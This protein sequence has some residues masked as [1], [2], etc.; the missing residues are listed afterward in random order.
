MTFNDT[1]VFNVGPSQIDVAYQQ[2]GDASS[3]T[4]LLIQGIGTQLLGWPDGFVRH[5]S[6]TDCS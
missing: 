6:S 4:V 3:P 5:L 2:I 1:M